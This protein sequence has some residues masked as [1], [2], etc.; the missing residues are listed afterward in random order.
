MFV[1]LPDLPNSGGRTMD[2]LLVNYINTLMKHGVDFKKER[3]KL[4][5]VFTKADLIGDLPPNLRQYLMKDPL[6]AAVNSHGHQKRMH[7]EDM[8]EYIEVMESV[9][10]VIRDW[11]GRNHSGQAFLNLA[12]AKNIDLRFSLISSTGAAVNESGSMLE[13]LSPRRVLD[14]FFWA[15]ELQSTT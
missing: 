2:M 8:Q 1:S 15:L 4:V 9:S 6:W 13:N 7:A 3:R 11:V 12:N 14:P 5:V 10:M